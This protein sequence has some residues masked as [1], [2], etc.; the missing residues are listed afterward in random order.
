MTPRDILARFQTRQDIIL[1]SIREIVEIES[2]SHFVDGSLASVAWIKDRLSRIPSAFDVE[3]VPADGLGEHLV[4][5]AFPG[6]EKPVLL[7]GHTD[8]VHP[9]GTNLSNPTRIEGDRFFGCGIFDM[10]ANIVLILEALQYFAE[11]N[12]APA[13]PISILL[14]CDEEVGSPTGRPLVEQE[15]AAAKCC[16][17][18]EPS[19]NGSVKTARKGT[20]LYTVKA[21]GVPAHAG[22]EPENGA[23][24]I[25]E[26]AR[27]IGRIS[28]LNDPSRGTSVNVTTV[29]GG[30]TSNVI[31]EHAECEIDV[32]FT[33]VAEGERIGAE[34][35]GIHPQ[36]G[37]VSLKVLGGINRP[38]LERTDAVA[39]LFENAK[40]I[41]AKFDYELSETQVGGA[42]DGNFVGALGVP[43]LDGLGVA[44]AGAHTLNEYINIGDIAKRA[45]LLTLMLTSLNG[46]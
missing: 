27:Q 5:R 18:L 10:K 22:L 34:I 21:H 37:R 45:T 31:P 41:A 33:S 17:V 16:Y 12:I 32:R 20:G 4:V 44:G 11:H 43:V 38:P 2:P 30:T 42:S 26:L 39:D 29:K 28:D 40:S 19:F 14:S 24:A 15:A 36:D 6:A 25:V 13:G 1:R 9:V 23:S 3:C 46:E 7:L 35:D 8:T